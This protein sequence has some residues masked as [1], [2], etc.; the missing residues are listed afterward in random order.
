M[1]NIKISQYMEQIK[2]EELKQIQLQ[3]MD[4]VHSFCLENN[5]KY[6]LAYG[7]L[8]GAIRHKGFIPWDDDIDIAMPRPDYEKFIRLYKKHKNYQVFEHSI[9]KK[10]HFCYAKV[11]D[12]RTVMNEYMYKKEQF[13]VYIDIFPIDGISKRHNQIARSLQLV[14]FIN[15]KRAIISMH[16]RNILKNI[17]L[18]LGKIILSTT[19]IEKLLQ[20]SYEN[21]TL[22]NYNSSDEVGNIAYPTNE[23]EIINKKYLEQT[24]DHEFE[25]R[26]YKI[27]QGYDL[28]LRQLY[29][30]YMKFPPKEQQVTH[31]NFTA[32]WK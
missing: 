12:T 19:S 3:I 9:N 27:P 18:L 10:Y 16:T 24:I 26:I 32:Y 15:T 20:K 23:K 17:V 2:T 21:A 25:N 11:A 22:V 5:I 1:P 29:G 28:W 7:T 30:D 8:I 6:F 4:D 13:G 14:K 31:H